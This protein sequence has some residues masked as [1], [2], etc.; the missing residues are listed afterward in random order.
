MSNDQ[1]TAFERAVESQQPSLPLALDSR[2][3]S[4]AYLHRRI[5]AL[6]MQVAELAGALADTLRLFDGDYRAST[7]FERQMETNR[8]LLAKLD[9][10]KDAPPNA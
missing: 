8:A 1:R 4:D 5:V 2:T 9:A 6:E 3:I 10:G 7:R